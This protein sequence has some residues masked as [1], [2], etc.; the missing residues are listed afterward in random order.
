VKLFGSLHL[1]LL[2][3]IAATAAALAWMTKRGGLPARSTRLTV[4]WALLLN[5]LGW[6]CFRYSHEGVHLRNLP[7]QLCDLTVWLSV[8]SCLTARIGIVEFAYFAGIAGAGM[9]LLT[10][11]LWSPWP[12]YPAIY[13]FVAHGGIVIA[14]S[15]MAFGGIVEF[16]RG[17]VWRA[18]GCLVGY[19][20]LVG[21]FNAITGSNYMYLCRKPNSATLLDQLGPW[22]LYL[23]PAA[24]V[25]LGL[26][27]LL[28]LPVRP[29]A[30]K[31]LR[32]P[33]AAG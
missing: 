6:W 25:G 9:A 5:E 14:V 15:L 28:W 12:S 11:D 27:W 31:S 3:A 17:A 29:T 16:R 23:L 24:A 19:A 8:L 22:P 10:P 13:F 2:G 26:F 32:R 1:A 33:P 4:G 21:A 20:I 7:L 18:Y 30:R